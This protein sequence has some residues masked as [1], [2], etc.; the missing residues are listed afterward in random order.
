MVSRN[1]NSQN[2][3]S[4]SIE[5]VFGCHKVSWSD[6]KFIYLVRWENRDYDEVNFVKDYH[7]HEIAPQK[8]IDYLKDNII[9]Q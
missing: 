2:F 9:W 8:L 7:L 5:L 4:K 6:T 3:T 1:N